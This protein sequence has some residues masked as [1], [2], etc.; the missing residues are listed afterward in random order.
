MSDDYFDIWS[1]GTTVKNENYDTKTIADSTDVLR[2]SKNWEI[3]N[4]GHVSDGKVFSRDG[5]FRGFVRSDNRP[6]D[7]KR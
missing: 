6:A 3:H 4:T 2:T 5:I 1:D 7:R